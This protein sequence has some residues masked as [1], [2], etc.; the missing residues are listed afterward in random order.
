MRER[1]QFLRFC[2]LEL[3][4][5]NLSIMSDPLFRL[6]DS[7]ATFS[8][9]IGGNFVAQKNI[10]DSLQRLQD[11]GRSRSQAEFSYTAITDRGLDYRPPGHN[12]TRQEICAFR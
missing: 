4:E 5:Q 6:V 2:V 3:V 12:L 9:K 1:R 8:D 11:I 7:F 10:V